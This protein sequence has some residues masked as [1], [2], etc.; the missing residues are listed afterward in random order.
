[1]STDS[2][3]NVLVCKIIIDEL[4]QFPVSLVEL[5]CI[6]SKTL[7]MGILQPGVK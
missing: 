2:F 4:V 3:K 6:Q 7:S 5:E 1:M